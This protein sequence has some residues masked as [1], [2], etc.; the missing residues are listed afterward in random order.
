M[1]KVW[2][3]LRMAKLILARVNKR[4]LSPK[5]KRLFIA[6]LA[7]LAVV[8][9]T[10]PF[11][12]HRGWSYAKMA[13]DFINSLFNTNI[14]ETTAYRIESILLA[15]TCDIAFIILIIIGILWFC[16]VFLRKD[17]ASDKQED[18]TPEILDELKAMNKQLSKLNRKLGSNG[19]H[20]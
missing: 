16:E 7:T 17:K 20:K 1:C 15:L 4:I 18:K 9:A 14:A 11:T 8:H 12:I 13:V 19:K 3:I 6:G 5:G 10:M 2:G